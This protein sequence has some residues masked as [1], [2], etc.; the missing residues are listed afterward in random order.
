MKS[1]RKSTNQKAAPAGITRKGFFGGLA[2]VATSVMAGKPLHAEQS[3][4]NGIVRQSE[5]QAVIRL[6]NQCHALAASIRMRLESGAEMERGKLGVSSLAEEP[7]GKHVG[8]DDRCTGVAGL[9]IMPV[10]DL[11]PY[12]KLWKDHPD[13]Q[14]RGIVLV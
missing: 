8:Q 10:K 7:V 3:A 12:L 2:A 1:I 4:A 5:L 9:D 13:H 14:Y 6:N 11:D